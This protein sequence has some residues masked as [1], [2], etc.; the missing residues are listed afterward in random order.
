MNTHVQAAQ[1]T[2][3]NPVVT[4]GEARHPGALAIDVGKLRKK[5]GT[6]SL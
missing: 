1:S 5:D 6:W 2:A 4:P 3:A